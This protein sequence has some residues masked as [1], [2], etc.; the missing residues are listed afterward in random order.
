MTPG[1]AHLATDRNTDSRAP[2][3]A[4]RHSG[5]SSRV[6]LAIAPNDDIIATSMSMIS[7]VLARMATATD[8]GLS[9]VCS[10]VCSSSNWT[11][12]VFSPP[13]SKRSSCLTLARSASQVIFRSI[14]VLLTPTTSAVRRIVTPEHRSL[15]TMSFTSGLRW[16]YVWL[17]VCELN[18]FPH[19]RQRYRGTRRRVRSTL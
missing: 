3:L 17:W 1:F 19:A 18:D 2:R 7:P 5:Y 15:N 12:E 13:S 11:S 10:K 9:R 16:R 6:R 4:S 8:T 14:V